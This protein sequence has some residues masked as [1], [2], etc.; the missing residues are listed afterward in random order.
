MKQTPKPGPAP[1]DPSGPV[2]K[3]TVS[4]PPA[5]IEQVDALA[6]RNGTS[7]SYVVRRSLQTWLPTAT[8][9][10]NLMQGSITGPAFRTFFRILASEQKDPARAQEI[11][12]VIAALDGSRPTATESQNNSTEVES[13]RQ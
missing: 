7:R 11:R 8:A 4:L 12:D 2:Q 6:A 9:A 5:I 13:D 10:A 1:R 3:V